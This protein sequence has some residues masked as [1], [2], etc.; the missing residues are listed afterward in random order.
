MPCAY[1][2][3]HLRTT[4]LIF[5]WTEVFLF[6]FSASSS[7]KPACIYLKQYDTIS[8]S[9]IEFISLSRHYCLLETSESTPSDYLTLPPVWVRCLFCFSTAPL[10]SISQSTYHSILFFSLLECFSPRNEILKGWE[11][12]WFVAVSPVFSPGFGTEQTLESVW[13]I[14]KL[15]NYWVCLGQRS[16]V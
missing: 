13:W 12:I 9:Y 14:N 15:R 10:T 4:C 7:H 6:C 11:C 16:V 3:G 8:S 2:S 5:S 1:K